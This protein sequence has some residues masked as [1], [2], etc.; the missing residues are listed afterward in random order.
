MG[1][2]GQ[3]FVGFS[4]KLLSCGDPAIPPSYAYH[5]AAIFSGVSL[6]MHEFDINVQLASQSHAFSAGLA[7]MHGNYA[8]AKCNWQ[9]NDNP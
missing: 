9:A 6:C 8:M 5:T 7:V 2:E 4:L 3:E 1:N